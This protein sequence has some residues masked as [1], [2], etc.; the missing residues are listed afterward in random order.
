MR[1]SS[2][3]Q[4][5]DFSS[6]GAATVP[7]SLLSK[8]K[9]LPEV[10]AASGAVSPEASNVADIIGSTGKKVGLESIGGS[11]DPAGAQFSPLKLKSGQWAQGPEQVV[12]DAGTGGE[13][14]SRSCRRLPTR[15]AGR[16]D[17]GARTQPTCCDRTDGAVPKPAFAFRTA[18]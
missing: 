12:I 15:R 1:S 9:A 18:R 4:I 11:F 10:G 7:E 14:P 13:D 5:V 6:S 16:S 2:G 8:V 17:R 3:K